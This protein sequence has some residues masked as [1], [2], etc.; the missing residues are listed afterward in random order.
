MFQLRC[1]LNIQIAYSLTDVSKRNII[2]EL[3][4][5]QTKPKSTSALICQGNYIRNK[6]KYLSVVLGL[7]KN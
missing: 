4:K 6:Q 1:R 3:C 5:P 7:Q 2:Y